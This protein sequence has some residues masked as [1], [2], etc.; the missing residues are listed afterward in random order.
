MKLFNTESDI[1]TLNTGDL[2]LFAGK[3]PG[4]TGILD[5]A[6]SYFTQSPYTHVGVVLKDPVFIHPSLKGLYLWESGWENGNP[7]PQDGKVKLGVQ[8]TPLYEILDSYKNNGY[9]Y[10][11]KIINGRELF[12]PEKLLDIHKVVYD[13]PYDIIP[14]DWIGAITRKDSS[15]QKTS[16]FWCS[17]LVAYIY[18]QLGILPNDTDW[19]ITR[20]CDFSSS[21]TYLTYLNGFLLSEDTILS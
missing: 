8:I 21:K 12:T 16:R 15:P 5:K 20:P 1:S 19:S 18:T 10:Y 6:I 13:K 4:A 9:V 3:C 11:R 7:D 2:L 17:A 14:T